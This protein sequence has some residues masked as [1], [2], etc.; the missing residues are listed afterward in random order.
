MAGQEA[1]CASLAYVEFVSASLPTRVNCRELRKRVGKMTDP[2]ADMLTRVKN[3][4]LAKHK[5]ISLPHSQ[6]KEEL[7]KLLV[8]HGYLADLKV[9]QEKKSPKKTMVVKLRYQAKKPA[10]DNVKRISKPGLRVYA[11]VKQLTRMPR[12]LGVTIISTPK[13]LLTLDEAKKTNLGGE[14]ICR[15]W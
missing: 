8:R 5:S 9:E 12:R 1:F 6:F 10:L 11:N 2:I 3:G 7:G 4:Y 15:V 13:G 14:V